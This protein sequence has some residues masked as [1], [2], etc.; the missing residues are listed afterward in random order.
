MTTHFCLSVHLVPLVKVVMGEK[1]EW[2]IAEKVK[3]ELRK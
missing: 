3:N 1:T 2:T